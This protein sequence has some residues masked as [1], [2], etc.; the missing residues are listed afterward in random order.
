MRRPKFL[1]YFIDNLDYTGVVVAV[2]VSSVVVSTEVVSSVV[3]STVVVS[4]VVVSSVVVSS[5]VVSSVV[6]PSVVGARVVT[7]LTEPLLQPVKASPRKAT[8]IVFNMFKT[9]VSYE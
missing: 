7:G 9:D 2:V 5:V 6:V 1:I 8:A 4:S 3:V